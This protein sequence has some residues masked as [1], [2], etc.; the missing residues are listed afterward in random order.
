M[1]VACVL[2][3]H[4]KYMFTYTSNLIYDFWAVCPHVQGKIDFL[5]LSSLIYLSFHCESRFSNLDSNLQE[6]EIKV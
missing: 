4:D 2:Q 3:H 6:E 5:S 1:S